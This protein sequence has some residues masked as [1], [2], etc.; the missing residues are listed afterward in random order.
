MFLKL[1]KLEW[2]SFFRSASL[3]KGIGVKLLLGFFALYFLISFLALGF[4]LFFILKKESAIEDPIIWVNN[5]LLFWFLGEFIIR[6]LLQNLPVVDIKP[7]LA[8]FIPRRRIIHALLT[9]SF[10]SFYNF[11]TI[12]VALP[13]MIVNMKESSYGPIQLIGWFIGVLSIVFFLNYLNLWIQKHFV[14]GIR[15]ILPFIA[16]VLALTLIEYLGIYSISALFGQFFTLILT[17]PVFCILPLLLTLYS[18]RLV[19]MD[20]KDNLYL[21]TYLDTST[22]NVNIS[23]LS[24]LDRFGVLAPFIQLDLKIDYAQ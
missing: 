4:G 3:G 1:F 17:Y 22:N 19:F 24:W 10:Y 11:L 6:F 7:L 2:K 13:F 9:K 14:K 23:A 18:Y 15:T 16:V 20:L 21:D 12:A 5:Y 8:Q